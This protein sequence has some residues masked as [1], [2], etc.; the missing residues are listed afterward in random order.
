MCI[1]IIV[2]GVVA[3]I[4]QLAS[5]D[6]WR[7]F[8]K[9]HNHHHHLNL[10]TSLLGIGFSKRAT[11]SSHQPSSY[12][13][14]CELRHFERAGGHSLINKNFKKY[15]CSFTI[16]IYLY[17]I[18][19]HIKVVNVAQRVPML[20]C[21]RSQ[22][23]V[24]KQKKGCVGGLPTKINDRNYENHDSLGS[25]RRITVDVKDPSGRLCLSI[26]QLK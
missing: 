7:I 11:T 23:I 10:R 22:H 3:P 21:Q 24:G 4:V 8:D 9:I 6:S 25:K 15:F 13:L 19:T 18:F 12:C 20:K 1:E 26:H 17:Y 16:I 5:P 2:S 14:F